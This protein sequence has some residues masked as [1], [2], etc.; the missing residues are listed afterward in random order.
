MTIDRNYYDRSFSES[1]IPWS[2][3]IWK[4]RLSEIV[5]FKDE[6]TIEEFIG[7]TVKEGFTEIQQQFS[8]Y[9]ISAKINENENPLQIE[10]EIHHSV[11]NN[12]IYGVRVESKIVSEYLQNEKNLPDLEGNITYFPKAYFGDARQGYDI[13]YFTQNELISDVLKHYER[14]LEIIS[15]QRNEMFISSNA[16]RR[17]K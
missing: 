1:V 4:Q 12:F 15:E 13:Q 11:V 10:I 17:K 6:K 5:S 2:G 8:E 3:Q 14:F 16:N 9:G 7:T